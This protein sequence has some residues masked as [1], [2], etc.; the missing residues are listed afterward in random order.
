MKTEE[1][2]EKTNARLEAFCDGVFAIALTLLIL[3]LKAPVAESIHSSGDLWLY[4]K[5]L[6][7]SGFAFLLSFAV[8]AISWVN[9]HALL[10]LVSGSN[11]RFIYA[12][13]FLLL[14]I[15]VIP[16]T[17]ALLAEF[18]STESAAPAVVL[19]SLFILLTNIGWILI[20]GSVLDT[21]GMTR[22]EAA[23]KAVEAVGRQS[24]GAFLIYLSCTLL[25]F[26]F[27]TLVS[28]IMTLSWLAW[29]VLGLSI[30]EKT[31]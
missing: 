21:P 30:N 9:H 19:Y 13:I 16:F 20:I 31:A 15:A 6:L 25:A 27:P 11:P 29:L 24:R 8:I 4:L 10:K 5:H 22:S 14:T 2:K 28:V 26:W 23:R 17:T 3:E 12:N 7:P 18:V 1:I